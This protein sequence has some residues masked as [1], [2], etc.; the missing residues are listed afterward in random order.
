MRLMDEPIFRWELYP[1][2]WDVHIKTFLGSMQRYPL[3]MLG[4]K[5]KFASIH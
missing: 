5:R 2:A 3:N 1:G 4:L